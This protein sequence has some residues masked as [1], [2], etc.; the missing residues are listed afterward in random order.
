[1]AQIWIKCSKWARHVDCYRRCSLCRQKCFQPCT[2]YRQQHVRHVIIPLGLWYSCLGNCGSF[3]GEPFVIWPVAWCC[4][5][6]GMGL[7]IKRWHVRLPPVPLSVTVIMENT[8]TWKS[9]PQHVTSA[10]CMSVFRGHLKAFLFH[11]FYHNFCNFCNIFGHLNR[12]F[13]LSYQLQIIFC[14]ILLEINPHCLLFSFHYYYA[15]CV[16]GSFTKM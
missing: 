11:D 1:M 16:S 2:E 7:V 4:N 3:S 10:P 13:S 8:R 6:Y 9:L 5:G 12:F 15:C 14:W